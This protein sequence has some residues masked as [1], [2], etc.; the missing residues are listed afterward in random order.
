MSRV[1]SNLPTTR[2]NN[3][4]G[5]SMK[6]IIGRS[7]NNASSINGIGG[8]ERRAFNGRS[9]GP[10]KIQKETVHACPLCNGEYEDPR[11]LPCTHTYCFNCI[12][13]KLIKNSRLTCPKCHYQVSLYIYMDL[14]DE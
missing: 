6:S 3:G 2:Y 11:V 9:T 4:V 14:S 13:D 1:A 5:Q 7:T 8:G 10:S 12:R